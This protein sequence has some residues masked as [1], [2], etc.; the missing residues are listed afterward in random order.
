MSS[1]QSVTQ[2]ERARVCSGPFF[3]FV[4]VC[5]FYLICELL[6]LLVCLCCQHLSDMFKT[7]LIGIVGS[8]W[9]RRQTIKI[10]KDQMPHH[11][12]SQLSA[13]TGPDWNGSPFHLAP[14]STLAS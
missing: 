1:L 13:P 11:F 8:G 2:E 12:I 14:A 5:F 7:I 4:V 10:I 3:F 9:I 6:S